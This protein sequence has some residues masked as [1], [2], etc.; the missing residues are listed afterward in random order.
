MIVSINRSN[1]NHLR[2]SSMEFF[3]GLMEAKELINVSLYNFFG[4]NFFRYFQFDMLMFLFETIFADIVIIGF[5]HCKQSAVMWPFFN[6]C[7]ARQC[8]VT[9]K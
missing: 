8:I 4:N 7:K 2:Q 1:N 9:P 6:Q 5:K 3:Q